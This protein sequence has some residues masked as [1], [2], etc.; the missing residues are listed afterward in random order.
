MNENLAANATKR[1]PLPVGETT[2]QIMEIKFSDGVSGPNSKTPGTPWVRLDAKLE[3]TD[4]EYLQ[5]VAG[6]PE[7]AVT[8]LGIMLDMQGGVPASGPNKNIRLGRL[9]D[10]TGTNGKP[11]NNMVGQFIRIAIGHKPHPT[12]P[13]GGVLDEIVSY[14]KV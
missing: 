9:R 11:L 14:T 4:P 2:A 6:Q 10:A 5:G 13:D 12:D 7:K 8:F 1:D 3:I